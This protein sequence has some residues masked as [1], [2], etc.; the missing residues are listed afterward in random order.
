MVEY[1]MDN[2][3]TAKSNLEAHEGT[4]PLEACRSEWGENYEMVEYCVEN[5]Y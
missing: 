5:P 2:Q 4:Y 1:C 3:R